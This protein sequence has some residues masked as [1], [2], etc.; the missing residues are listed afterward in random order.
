[1]S[2]PAS[3]PV[4]LAL[5]RM[6]ASRGL[7][8]AGARL[9]AGQRDGGQA[10]GRAQLGKVLWLSRKRRAVHSPG[11]G[12]MTFAR[13]STHV[14]IKVGRLMAQSKCPRTLLLL[15]LSSETKRQ[16][17]LWVLLL[18]LGLLMRSLI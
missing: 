8:R 14:V 12:W 6:V 15:C 4:Y 2:A 10:L 17:A 18:T 9:V 11:C 3:A 13:F 1:M 16:V 7:A 5:I